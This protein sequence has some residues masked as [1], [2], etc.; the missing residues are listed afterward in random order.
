MRPKASPVRRAR[1]NP[2]ENHHMIGAVKMSDTVK[3][4][5]YN[6]V[7]S[8]KP[9]RSYQHKFGAGVSMYALRDGS[10]L[11]KGPKKLWNLYEVEDKE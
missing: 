9:S 1:K 4:L 3:S 2:R 5:V 11:L 10:I 6:N 7:F 8:A